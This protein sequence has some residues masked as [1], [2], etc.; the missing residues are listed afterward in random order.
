MLTSNVTSYNLSSSNINLS[1]KTYTQITNN[2]LHAKT[3]LHHCHC[4]ILQQLVSFLNYFAYFFGM[5]M[6]L[7]NIKMNYIYRYIKNI[8]IFLVTEINLTNNKTFFY[9]SLY[10]TRN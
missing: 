5:K 2:I 3:T 9:F 8:S 1:N 10:N 4:D 6:A 7:S